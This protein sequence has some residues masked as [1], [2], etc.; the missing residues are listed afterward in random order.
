VERR[1][2]SWPQAVVYQVY[3]RSFADSNGD[4]VGD[5]PGV[6]GKVDYPKWLGVD[7]IWL[8]PINPSPNRDFGYD[9]SDYM[10]VDPSLG[11]LGDLDRR[12]AAEADASAH[13]PQEAAPGPL[14]GA[15]LAG[16]LLATHE[17]R[18]SSTTTSARQ[19]PLCR[20][21]PRKSGSG[22][23]PIR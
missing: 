19:R 17:D 23:R 10:D 6:I 1:Q 3:V 4:G 9:V 8:S 13:S 14:P 21:G 12:L 20:S 18:R 16:G 5:L 15:S 22:S 11:T 7:A 2:S